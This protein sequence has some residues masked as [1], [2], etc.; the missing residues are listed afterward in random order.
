MDRGII[1]D[2]DHLNG[3]RSNENMP[4]ERQYATLY[5]LATAIFVLSVTVSEIIMF[6]LPNVLDSNL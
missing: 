6:E 3:P 5:V 1:L 4:I 2:L